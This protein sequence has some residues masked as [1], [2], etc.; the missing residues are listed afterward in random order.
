MAKKKAKGRQYHKLF[1]LACVLNTNLIF[2]WHRTLVIK[3]NLPK[4]FACVF[5]SSKALS[6]GY[7]LGYAVNILT[8]LISAIWIVN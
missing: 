8:Y 4:L 1:A 3:T 5:F 2:V 6:F 7:K